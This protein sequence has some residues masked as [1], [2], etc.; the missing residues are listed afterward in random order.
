MTRPLCLI[1]PPS[2]FL[3]DERMF[4]TLGI[5]KVAASLEQAGHPVELLDLSGV[6]NYETAVRDHAVRSA[7]D[8][9]GIT[10]TTPQ[11]PAATIIAGELK[12]VRPSAR[13]VLGG[14]HITLVNA[15]RKREAKAGAAG[16]ATRAFEQLCEVFDI[17]VA[18]DG[19][20]AVFAAL[21]PQ[22][23]KL[24]D[25]D[26]P[27]SDLFLTNANL[28][29]EPLPARHL[30]DADSYHYEI[31][32]VRAL[33]MI[34]QLGCPFGCRFCGGRESPMLRRIRLRPVDHVISEMVHLQRTYGIRGFM[35]YDDELNVNPKMLD[36]MQAIAR[37]GR[38]LRVDFRLR[39]FIKA[40][41]F[42]D[43]QA[44]AMSEAGFRCILIGFESGSPRILRNIQKRATVEDN[45]RCIEIARRH[46]LRVK[47]LMSIGHP[48]ES[49]ATVNDTRDWLLD[50]K[51]DDFDVTIIT[52]YP[53]SDY[54]DA[55]APVEGQPDLWVYT[56]NG[57][58]L[59]SY[60]LDYR[61]VADYYKGDPDGGYSSFV[62]TD[63]LHPHDLVELRGAVE[64]DVRTALGIPFNHA[65]AAVRYE[66]SMGQIG[67]LPS[68]ILRSTAP[69]DAAA[70]N[71]AEPD[72]PA[73]P[74]LAIGGL[75]R[76]ELKTA[77]RAVAAQ[78]TTS[79]ARP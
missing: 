4:M 15:S 3:L 6:S 76:P 68:R 75:A 58:R 30:I 57:D 22:A 5:L 29:R 34:C 74:L 61:L 53:G 39:G 26:D 44:Q 17:L 35:L 67:P 40:E 31:D 70:A 18:G 78:S 73:V 41:L 37:T 49:A 72:A 66:H 32:G 19:E 54:Y 65:A 36:L 20:H 62:Y 33:S 47:A 43:E 28:A 79:A 2:G 8:W 42:S 46:N 1:T 10:A 12:R 71:L 21:E 27:R 9:F 38:D 69:G 63:H 7:A 51:P 56:V 55:A 45:T 23:P 13:V 52:T 77:S 24:V 60:E 50:V 14:P 11:M 59:F 25:A 64:R 48:G 16:R